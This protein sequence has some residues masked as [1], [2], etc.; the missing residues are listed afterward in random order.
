MHRVHVLTW[1]FSAAL[2]SLVVIRQGNIYLSLAV[3]AIALFL[4][5]KYGADSPWRGALRISLILAIFTVAFRLCIA[6]FIGVGYDAEPL[7][8]LPRLE[9]PSWLAGIIIGGPVSSARLGAALASGI[10]LAAIIILVG[11]AQSLSS[12]RRLLRALPTPFYD[13]ALVIVIATSLVPQFVQSVQ[14]IRRAFEIR[15]LGH[16]SILQIATPV[17]EDC[18]ERTLALAASMD[19]RGFGITRKRTRYRKERFTYQDVLI[20]SVLIALVVFV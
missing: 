16:P 15:D 7:F 17:V 11:A 19:I 20:I 18:L 4:G 3:I 1:W 13:F 9:L 12:P 2:V 5:Q 10:T 8:T 6:T 14:R